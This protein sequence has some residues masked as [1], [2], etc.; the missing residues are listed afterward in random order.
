MKYI[1]T[2]TCNRLISVIEGELRG[3]SKT[4]NLQGEQN[5][6]IVN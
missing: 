1:N 5:L 2:I 4:V 3:I 6:F